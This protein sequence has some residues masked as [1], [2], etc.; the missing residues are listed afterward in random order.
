MITRRVSL[1]RIS[2]RAVMHALFKIMEGNSS[3]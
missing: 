1:N 2:W 3:Q